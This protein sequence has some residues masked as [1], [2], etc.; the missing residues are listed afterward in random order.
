MPA[1]FAP[2][3]ASSCLLIIDVQ[4]RFTGVIPAIAGDGP[5][6]R[7]CRILLEAARL[8]AV[9]ALISE[10]VP[11]KLG[12]TIAGLLAVQGE[13]PRCSKAHFSAY[14]E[15]AIRDHLDG[16]QRSD[17]V[18]AGVE[19]HVCVLATAADLLAAGRRV[20]VAGDAVASRNPEHR[21]LALIALRDLG[22]L[23][24]PVE[25][26]VFRWQRQAGVGVF[27]ALSQL[28]K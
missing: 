1:T 9:P 5:V 12:P 26:I 21:D 25:S 6:A 10:Q 24:V 7:N 4:E 14:A 18:L 15:P 16:W 8:L 20:I 13:T 22:A 23:V 19:T 11:D 27:K 17:V 28:V 2:L 3:P